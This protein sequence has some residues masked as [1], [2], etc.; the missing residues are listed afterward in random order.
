MSVPEW[1]SICKD[2]FVSIAACVTAYVAIK[3]VGTWQKELRG[4]AS[5][6]VARELIKSIYLLRDE[7]KRCRSPF[8][9]GDEFPDYYD[10]FGKR[11]KEEE[12]R[13]WAYV[14]TKRWKPAAKAT[15]AFEAC[16][17]EAEVLWG[18]EIRKKKDELKK[19]VVQLHGGIEAY[20][21]DKNAGGKHF[22]NDREFE[23]NV[24]LDIHD[25]KAEENKLTQG[26]EESI[27][28]LESIICP[29]LARD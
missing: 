12:G 23:K 27:K 21:S 7:I 15:Q 19:W 8:I 4:K 2:V 10:S 29:H 3:G 1:F 9:W 14:Y 17:L 11:T 24:K 26:V 18:D 6:D 28:G 25:K 16:A 22:K 5:F 20:I 13:A